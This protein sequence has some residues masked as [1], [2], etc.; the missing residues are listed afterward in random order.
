MKNENSTSFLN[1]H[2]QSSKTTSAENLLNLKNKS[3]L[4]V[5]RLKKSN[6]QKELR[7]I[8]RKGNTKNYQVQPSEITHFENYKSFT[9]STIKIP[10]CIN[11]SQKELN[12]TSKN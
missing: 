5:D 12:Q 6:F 3:S 8:L 2:N 7:D 11:D 1:I 9:K 10:V 4:N